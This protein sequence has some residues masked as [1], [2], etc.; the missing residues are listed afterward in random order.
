[1]DTGG[2][3]TFNIT[4]SDY[5]VGLSY[6]IFSWNGTGVWD[7]TSNA[8]VSGISAKVSVNKSTNLSQGNTVGYRWYANDSLNQWNMSLLR[9]F[10]VVNSVPT[11][12][13]PIINST[14]VWNR[15]NG[16]IYCWNQSLSDVDGDAINIYYRWFNNSKLLVGRNSSSL[17][18]GNFSKG[19]NITCLL[20]ADFS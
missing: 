16:T 17:G 11:H 1:M 8:T 4:I 19:Y 18:P 6:Y 7:N 20:N 12:T 10:T 14:D 15:T 2:N 3:A 13:A 5:G 9:I